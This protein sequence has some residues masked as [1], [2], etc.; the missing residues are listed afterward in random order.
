MK[1]FY[2]DRKILISFIDYVCSEIIPKSQNVVIVFDDLEDISL[3]KDIFLE[4]LKL[5]KSLNLSSNEEIN[6]YSFYK[7]DNKIDVDCVADLV[8]F[9][10]NSSK[11]KKCLLIQDSILKYMI[12]LSIEV[13][14][15]IKNSKI[16]LDEFISKMIGFGYKRVS[17][18]EVL[19]E[20]SVRG[21]I[22]DLWLNS[23]SYEDENKVLDKQPLRVILED[24]FVSEIRLL[25]ITSQRSVLQDNI[26][27]VEVYP[28]ELSNEKT[29]RFKDL[30]DEDVYEKIY[31]SNQFDNYIDGYFNVNKYFGEEELFLRNVR[32][33][34][35]QKYNVIIGY[36]HF[37]EYEKFKTLFEKH[38]IYEGLKFVKTSIHK[39][40]VNTVKKIFFVTYYDVFSK[41]E[42]YSV[43]TKPKVYEG[44]RLENIWEI[45]KGDY[46]VHLDY[47][48][49]K[50]LGFTTFNISGINK[51][52]ITLQFKNDA[53]VHI[54]ITELDKIEKYISISGRFPS[55]SA[56]NKESWEKVKL[57][58]KDSLKDFIVGLY[59]IYSQ[60]KRLPGIKFFGDKNLEDLFA[61]TFEYEETEDQIKAIQDVYKDMES[62]YPM[63]RIIVG[64]VGFGKT[65]V[66]LRATFRAVINEKQVVLLCP[67]TVLA[68]QHFITFNRRLE[69][70]GVKVEVIS[71][72]KKKDEIKFI[73]QQIKEGKVDV[74]I[75]T[76][77]LLDDRVE[78]FDLGLVIVDEEHKFGVRQKEKIRVKYSTEENIK[79]GNAYIKIMPDILYLTATPIPRTL[80]FGLQGIKDISLIEIPPFGRQPIETFISVYDE[81]IIDYAI[82]KELKRDGQIYYV[83]NNTYLIED[84]LAK[85]KKRF[86][87][88]KAEFIHSKL[89]S[90]KIEDI[91][92]KFLNKEIDILISTTIIEAG[93]DVPNVNTIIV[94]DAHK[95]GLSQLYQLR[96]RVGRR[97]KKAYCYF[98]YSKDSMTSDAKKR[99]AALMEFKS[100]GS[101]YHLALRDLEIRGAGEILGTKQHGYINEVGLNMYSKIVKQ[102]MEEVSV[103]KVQEKISPIVDIDVDASLSRDYI[104]DDDT[105]ISF[106]RKIVNVKSDFELSEIKEEIFDRFGKPK[107]QQKVM[108]EN[109]FLL[110]SLR[111]FMKEYNIKKIYQNNIDGQISLVFDSKKELLKFISK[112]KDKYKVV[113]ETEISLDNEFKDINLLLLLFKQI[114]N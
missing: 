26:N 64:D 103:G 96:G 63:D 35:F 3:Y 89:S 12:P 43:T 30:L 84:K 59:N 94:E 86:A 113:N 19:G 25:N 91:M 9:L 100:L 56:L 114:K 54:S 51:E 31:C 58:I 13:V 8:N 5:V 47:G 70:F 78:F 15:I 82:A 108:L 68:H 81:Q 85:I 105:R 11:N 7:D 2:F 18:V 32:N 52:F 44:L 107:G 112:I 95:F 38:K 67:T 4:Y 49:A 71:R 40:F 102:L 48:I 23:F 17:Y 110:S 27:K 72:L 36:S 60:R 42:I 83:Y 39:G 50:F 22:L 45:Q 41:Y 53:L 88:I 28:I 87:N 80:A 75:G 76:H 46:V 29:K 92:I 33:Y 6:V 97:D 14:N 90:R 109:L 104:P 24:D 101:G 57:R 10:K 77:I 62:C 65:E 111:L 20:F 16:N 66:A 34:L 1:K 73:L 106:Y 99:L 21:N 74:V 98:L 55:V 79:I 69:S 37:N 93:L 61:S